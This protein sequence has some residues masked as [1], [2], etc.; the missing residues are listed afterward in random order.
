[1]EGCCIFKKILNIDVTHLPTMMLVIGYPVYWLELYILRKAHGQTTGLATIA[2][3]LISI[4]VIGYQWKTMKVFIHDSILQF[5]ALSLFFKCLVLIGVFLSLCSL[6]IAFKASLLPPHLIQ[7]SDALTYH[8]TLPRQHLILGS[9]AHIPWAA[10][11]LFLLPIQLAL[12]PFWFVTT[13]PNKFPQFLFLLGLI[14]ISADLVRHFSRNKLLNVFFVVFAILGSHHVGIQMGTAMLDLVIAYLFFAALN[15]FLK[16]NM[17]WALIEFSFFFWSKSFM[18]IQMGLVGGAMVTVCILAQ[19]MNFK[20]DGIEIIV[21]KC[22]KQKKKIVFIF[23]I[24]SLLIGGP[25]LIKSIYYSGT[26]FFPLMTGSIKINKNIDENSTHWKSIMDSS[27]S[28][29]YAARNYGYGRSG[30]D[31]L[32]HFWIMA[33]PDKGVNNK[34]DYPL[35]LVY[36]LVLGPFIMMFC[37]RMRR[38]ELVIGVLFIILFWLSWWCG[39]HQ[40]RYLYVPVLLMLILVVSEIEIS[41]VFISCII[42]AMVLNLLSMFRSHRHDFGKSS[43]QVLRPRDLETLHSNQ[44]YIQTSRKGFINLDFRDV[45]FAQFPVRAVKEGLPHTLAL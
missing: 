18:P 4:Y 36:L 12:A 21:E 37:D 26:P 30:I 2:F 8:Y 15:S 22:K 45:P 31:F 23:L 32:K 38:K 43:T 3:L 19:K 16:G 11:D 41:K 27:E 1:V 39:S 25:F 5:K 13:L 6:S 20:I 34:Y 29:V 24:L 40:S 14:F 10:D 42:L 28:F 35:G 9:F 7:E 44:K 33:V 17:F